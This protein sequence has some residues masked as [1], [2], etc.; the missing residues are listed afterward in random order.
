MSVRVKFCRAA[1]T[2]TVLSGICV[3]QL[4]GSHD[5]TATSWRVP[6]DHVP[7][8]TKEICPIVNSTVSDGAIVQPDVKEKEN[9]QLKIVEIT[10][11]K[12]QIGGEFHTTIRIENHGK[13]V[14]RVPWE[15]DGERVTRMA[16]D[17]KEEG[18]EAVDISL[19]LG[20]GSQRGNRVFLKAA[21]ALFANF[22]LP[23]SYLDLPPES[24][25]DLK[26]AG[27]IEC[28]NT[29]GLC[30]NFERDERGELGASWYERQVT[31]RVDGCAEEHGNFVV[32]ELE[33]K[34]RP[35]TV[36]D[37]SASAK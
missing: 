18:Y 12:L 37:S 20:T 6:V 22:D 35:V 36:L 14:V 15:T 5:F 7:T 23:S 34:I 8:P 27:R 30:S 17:G 26:I 1:L 19:Q 29:G 28:R 33:S 4:V 31:H 16:T 11:S 21:G 9:V 2:L 24:W 3:G 13:T 32:R 10:P 25:A